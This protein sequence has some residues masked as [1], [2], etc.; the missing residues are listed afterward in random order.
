MTNR[1]Y[2]NTLSDEERQKTEIDKFDSIIDGIG[3]GR[4]NHIDVNVMF[5]QY[6]EWLSQPH[7]TTADEDFA[8]I[9]IKQIQYTG[10]DKASKVIYC[11]TKE[12]RE[13]FEVHISPTETKI[14][15]TPQHEVVYVNLEDNLIRT[16]ADKK[17]KEVWG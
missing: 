16:I 17:R 3:A 5:Y 9:D 11:T 1:E 15:I 6:Q 13:Y 14:R 4:F 7:E 2:L 10:D 12:R 8:E